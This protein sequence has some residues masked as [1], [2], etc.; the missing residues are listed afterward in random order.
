M[1]IYNLKK[2]ETLGEL[3]DKCSFREGKMFKTGKIEWN[4]LHLG[5]N[6]QIT[7]TD[8]IYQDC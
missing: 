7:N 8:L 6:V 3:N 5:F 2:Q 1:R 4:Y